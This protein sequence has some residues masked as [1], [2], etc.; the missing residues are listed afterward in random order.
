MGLFQRDSENAD[1]DIS[2]KIAVLTDTVDVSGNYVVRVM[3]GDGAKDLDGT[4]GAFELSISIDG[5][6]AQPNPQVIAVEAAT[7]EGNIESLPF[8]TLAGEEVIAYVLSPNAADTDVDVTASL[9][10][11]TRALPAVA[12][13]AA[14]GIPISDAGGLDLDAL[15]MADKV[16]AYV[17]LLARSDAAIETDRSTELGEINADEASGAGNFSA[18]TE[19]V[20]AIRDRGDNGWIAATGF[21]V[22]G[23]IM[24]VTAGTGAGELDFTS[25]VIKSNLSQI[26]GTALTETAGYL[27]AAFKKL[28]NV[29]T[30][31]LVASDAMR[32]TELAAVASSYTPARAIKLDN[33]DAAISTRSSFD[34]SSDE[35]DVGKVKGTGVTNIDDFKANVSALA[36]E[37]TVNAVGVIATAIELVTI[38][39]DTGLVI[40]GAVYQFTTNALENGPT[41]DT[42]AIKLVTDKLDDTMELDGPI[43]RFTENALEEAPSS[44]GMSLDQ[45]IEGTT[46]VQDIFKIVNSMAAGTFSIDT[47]TGIIT[48]KDE[49][50][51]TL[52]T[53]TVASS[54]RTRGS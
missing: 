5:R 27:A 33:L 42:A 12:P 24:K 45:I 40:D 1:L 51:S 19:S 32:G 7:T 49:A 9:Q 50:G 53:V 29:A 16:L 46:T 38:K 14:G 48:F 35:V 25:G 3:L 54:G 6:V 15:A 4:G 30:P 47:A 8:I 34:S 23:D 17:Q 11:L 26:L 21:A 2:S 28:F 18:Q 44:T 10:D 52:F 31:L 20:E 43:Y 22:A 39:L 41:G 37:A 36:L 13:D